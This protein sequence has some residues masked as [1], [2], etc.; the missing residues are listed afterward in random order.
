MVLVTLSYA[1]EHKGAP[2]GMKK[3]V[4]KRYRMKDR[5]QVPSRPKNAPYGK[6]QKVPIKRIP[7]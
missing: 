5:P 6:I 4:K 2:R 3:R 1:T 7:F